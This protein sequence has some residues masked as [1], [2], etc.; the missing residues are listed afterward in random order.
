MI[1]SL[2]LRARRLQSIFA[3]AAVCLTL[4][5]TTRI[6]AQTFTIKELTP[7][8]GYS[9]SQGFAINQQGHI[10]GLSGGGPN[11]AT[12]ATL[13]IEGAPRDIH[14][15]V[16]QSSIGFAMN[17]R[18]EIAGDV[19]PDRSNS[20]AFIWRGGLMES[21][22]GGL[23]G[24]VSEAYGM[25]NSGTV[26]GAGGSATF[27]FKWQAGSFSQLLFLSGHHTARPIVINDAGIVAGA[28]IGGSGRSAVRWIGLTPFPLGSLG[29]SGSEAYGINASGQIVGW[30]ANAAG[31]TCAFFWDPATGMQALPVP[32]NFSY[33][34]AWNLNDLGDVVGTVDGRA[35]V[36]KKKDLTFEMI[37]VESHLPAES[38]WSDLNLSAINNKGQITGDGTHYDE[39]RGFLLE[40]STPVLI[41]VDAN[42]DGAIDF[43]DK[44]DR[45]TADRRFVFWLNNDRDHFDSSENEQDDF[46]PASGEPDYKHTHPAC[47][48][49]LE[50]FVRLH[51]RAPSGF[52]RTSS[53]W[54]VK[55]S[56]TEISEGSPAVNICPAVRPGLE[57]LSDSTAADAQVAILVQ[58]VVDG[59]AIDIPKNWFSSSGDFV[60]APLLLE[61]RTA[62]K[63]VLL[64]Q[65]YKDGQ[66][67]A[68]DKLYLDL[69]PV[70]D[71]YDHWTVGDTAAES[72]D[73][74]AIARRPQQIGA[75]QVAVEDPQTYLL[76]VHGWR[77]QPWER[78][79][80]AET[81][82]KRLWHL[83]YRGAFGMFSWPTEWHKAGVGMALDAQNF[84]RSEHK[85][86]RSAP[87]LRSVLEDLAQTFSHVNVLAHSMGNVVA[88]EA[89]LLEV[90]ENRPRPRRL[91]QT[92]LA[93]QAAS[94]A[95]AYD[96]NV[97]VVRKAKTPDVYSDY[98]LSSAPYFGGF[99]QASGRVIN[100]F[101]RQD[102]ALTNRVTWPY[103]QK[104]KPDSGYDYKANGDGFI[105]KD[106]HGQ[107]TI[108]TLP[109]D[110]DVI[111]SH[112]AAAYS[113]ALGA[114]PRVAATVGL[115]LQEAPFGFT[116]DARFH[117]AQFRSDMTLRRAYWQ[118]VLTRI[119]PQTP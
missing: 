38:G 15:P 91:V 112:I 1:S 44:A 78:R 19:R 87:G 34:Y 16:F 40:A 117:S 9:Y 96:A 27:G 39:F 111:F 57:Y 104:T 66:S 119:S 61:G 69:R 53:A 29:G 81:A 42:R 52:D 74:Y 95:G 6:S 60:V 4:L 36:W 21:I 106:G 37:D 100:L 67:Q 99:Q 73:P 26:V 56:V 18:D 80:F 45:T 77:M 47:R 63:G 5:A 62:G 33:S 102:Y 20:G 10:A 114:E 51:L 108:L 55:L 83:G 103:N 68:E 93:T 64:I 65:F 11:F 82:F 23:S 48:R 59:S 31:Q 115:D 12:H 84:D 97:P 116:N 13:W 41:Q 101:N 113:N 75:R 79:A 14:D 17:D 54:Q 110:R 2:A 86:W 107:Q 109:E 58:P 94:V 88:S 30:A 24:Y 25:N 43:E 71:L 90:H 32:A 76:F 8:A 28:S 85:A 105:R 72:F 89:L 118:F 3:T 50:D 49:D 92:Y 7:I 35:T 46:D 98:P 22:V 70:A